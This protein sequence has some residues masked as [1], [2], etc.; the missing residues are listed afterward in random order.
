MRPMTVVDVGLLLLGLS[1]G[2][3]LAAHGAQK[4][5][6]WWGGPGPSGWRGTIASMGF[7][8]VR[9]FAALSTAAELVGGLSLALGL[10]TSIGA[11]LVVAQSVVIVFHVHWQRGFWNTARGI[12]YPLQL[13]VVAVVLGLIGRGAL[14]LDGALATPG[15][16]GFGGLAG[17]DRAIV[18]T[19]P[20]TL[21]IA[22]LLGGAIAGSI[23]LLVPQA[24]GRRSVAQREQSRSH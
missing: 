13:A 10:F 17:L 18:L 8:P 22:L 24:A 9:L 4:A 6:G 11:A 19:P 5:F 16:F 23:A 21:R 12:E 3:T 15:L 2:L 7:R 1:V 14:S 20:L